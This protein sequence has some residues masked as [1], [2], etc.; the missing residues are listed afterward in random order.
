MSQQDNVMSFMSFLGCLF[1]N[2]RLNGTIAFIGIIIG[3]IFWL[4]GVKEEK[5]ICNILQQ[6]CIVQSTSNLNI[7]SERF[8]MKPENV[9]DVYIKPYQ[10]R[11]FYHTATRSFNLLKE[12][13]YAIYFKNSD[14]P[15]QRIFKEGYMN[16]DDAETVKNIIQ[17]KFLSGDDIVEV[18]KK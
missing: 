3:G 14:G 4:T 2:T 12:N 10:K 17:T 8:I 18:I 6:R 9:S 15:A 1:S 7:K 5:L 16:K 13:Y 11:T